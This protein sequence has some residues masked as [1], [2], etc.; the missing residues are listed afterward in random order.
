[1]ALRL[2][3]GIANGI[4]PRVIEVDKGM[5]LSSANMPWREWCAKFFPS[6]TSYP[7]APR[8]VRLWEW[9]EA[10]ER[11]VAPPPEI[12]C[13]PRA[14]AK[15]ATAELGITRLCVKLTR[16]LVLYVSATQDQA[17]KHVQSIASLM[18]IIGV[19]KIGRAHV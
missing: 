11:G 4:D 1:M 12:F 2:A 18:E 15:S 17:E 13:V 5:V 14:G 8:H 19:D 3:N 10:L 7:F 16:R 6:A 9:F